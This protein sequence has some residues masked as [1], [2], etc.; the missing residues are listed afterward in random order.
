MRLLSLKKATTFLLEAL[1]EYRRVLYDKGLLI[2][3]AKPDNI[4]FLGI[5]PEDQLQQL[6]YQSGFGTVTHIT[7]REDSVSI[8][9]TPEIGQHLKQVDESERDPLRD[10]AYAISG[11]QQNSLLIL[12]PEYSSEEVFICET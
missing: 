11:S 2:L 9:I 8:P 6:L 4:D 7:L 10:M 5:D 12:K 1:R 3:M